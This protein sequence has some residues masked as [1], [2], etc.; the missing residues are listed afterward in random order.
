MIELQPQ[1]KKCRL[2]IVVET[3]TGKEITEEV[4]EGK[5]EE[6]IPLADTLIK[7]QKEHDCSLNGVS[8]VVDG[9]RWKAGKV[10]EQEEQSG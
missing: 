6:L 3:K 1:G 7:L 8:V 2:E 4:I 5:S 10:V 9:K